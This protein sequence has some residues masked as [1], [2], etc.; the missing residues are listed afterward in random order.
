LKLSQI[1]DIPTML[2]LSPLLIYV[3]KL[4]LE[5]AKLPYLEAVWEHAKWNCLA[6]ALSVLANNVFK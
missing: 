4:H 2:L 5:W 6:V 3:T 1:D